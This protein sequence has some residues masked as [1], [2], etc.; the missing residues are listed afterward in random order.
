MS[1]RT[2][3]QLLDPEQHRA[4]CAAGGRAA[5]AK[6]G[7]HRFTADTAREAGRKGG[8]LVSQRPGHMRA[9]ALK[10]GVVTSSRPGHMAMIGARGAATKNARKL[11]PG[12]DS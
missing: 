6:P 4:V 1:N 9:L 3:F 8:L 11:A 7:A 12:G 2:G 5:Q 10:G